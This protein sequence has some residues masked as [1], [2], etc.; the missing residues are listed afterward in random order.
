MVQD[1]SNLLHLL[2]LTRSLSFIQILESHPRADPV[3]QELGLLAHAD[4][5]TNM[6]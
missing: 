5:V 3:R 6:R 4:G 1:K 2:F